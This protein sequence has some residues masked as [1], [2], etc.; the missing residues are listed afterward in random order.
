M[1]EAPYRILA[2]G[3]SPTSKLIEV[4]PQIFL[5][6]AQSYRDDWLLLPMPYTYY[7]TGRAWSGR[8]TVTAGLSR[9]EPVRNAEDFLFV[10]PLPTMRIPWGTTCAVHFAIDDEPD[11]SL[12]VVRAVAAFWE[13]RFSYWAGAQETPLFKQIFRQVDTKAVYY[14][15]TAGSQPMAI[16]WETWEKTPLEETLTW[17]WAEQP[18]ASMLDICQN[19][20]LTLQLDE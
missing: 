17:P 19:F 2:A 3:E 10:P 12:F 13:T 20:R 6:R 18:G 16:G 7:L 5:T 8:A 9:P 4:P 15:A 11:E 1:T 14:G